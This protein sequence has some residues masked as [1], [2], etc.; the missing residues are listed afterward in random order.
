[1]KVAEHVNI[2]RN[3]TT[4]RLRIF[5]LRTLSSRTHLSSQLAQNTMSRFANTTTG[6]GA[7]AAV[8]KK[9]PDDV[10]IVAA[11]RTALTKVSV[12]TT[13]HKLLAKSACGY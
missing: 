8:L 10:V 4:I 6:A 3:Q 7:K 13:L 2:P 5:H 12:A 9:N 11:T 1:M